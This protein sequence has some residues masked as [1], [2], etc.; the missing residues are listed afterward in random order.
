MVSRRAC[1][2]AILVP[3]IG[4]LGPLP[5]ADTKKE[6]K[7]ELSDL[8]LEV[9]ALQLLYQLDLSPRQMEA[10]AKIAKDT[11]P[12]A[13]ERKPGKGSEKLRT[14]LTDLRSALRKNDASKIDDLADKLD[15]LK[16][17]ESPSLD[18]SIEITDEAKKRAPEALRLLTA[19]Q[20]NEYLNIYE[21]IQDPAA[22]VRDALKKGLKSPSKDWT[23]LRDETAAEVGWLVGGFDKDKVAKVTEQTS[24]FLDKAHAWKEEELTKRQPDV[25]A[26]VQEIMGDVGPAE[27]LRHIVEHDLAEQLSNPQ[28]QAALEARLKEGK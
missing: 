18:D 20:M 14:L 1:L 25:E 23:T 27:V 21:E 28:M 22:S 5:A 10:L 8:S 16:D 7:A 13:R 6:T 11:A 24:T 3:L 12:P 17:K 2:A 26:A 19:R 4:L 15:E 9:E